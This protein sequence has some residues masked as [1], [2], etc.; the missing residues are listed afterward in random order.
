MRTRFR[1]QRTLHA[2]SSLGYMA[3]SC[4]AAITRCPCAVSGQHQNRKETLG[5]PW[6]KPSCAVREASKRHA[7]VLGLLG[8]R[9]T[10]LGAQRQWAVPRSITGP[11]CKRPTTSCRRW[12]ASASSG[13]SLCSLL[14]IVR[15]TV[16]R[17]SGHEAPGARMDGHRSCALRALSSAALR[18]RTETWLEHSASVRLNF[19]LARENARKY[20][21]VHL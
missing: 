3:A 18:T 10:R 11:I 21:G 19:S 14:A 1:A 4:P 15:P 9:H 12:R 13:R 6:L 7:F 16:A 20:L 8:R 5:V 2:L 17:E